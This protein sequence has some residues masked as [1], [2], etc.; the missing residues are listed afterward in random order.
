M[1][2]TGL[3]LL[4]I[5]FSTSIIAQTYLN[6]TEVKA[7]LKSKALVVTPIASD[8]NSSSYFIEIQGQ[9]KAHYHAKHTESIYV[10]SGTAE[11]QL[12]DSI[13]F[14]KKGDCIIIP[15]STIHSVN[16]KG[17][18]LKVLSIQAPQ[19]FGKDRIWVED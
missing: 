10:I 2:K 4:F 8:T 13:L 5:T 3:I 12:G 19:F 6:E 17:K 14:V 18:K 11:M 7:D 1:K 9:I 15:P 16:T